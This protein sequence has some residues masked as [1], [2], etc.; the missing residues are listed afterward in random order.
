MR[1]IPTVFGVAAPVVLALASISVGTASAASPP[2]PLTTLQWQAEI[3]Q[4]PAV[5][6]GCFH[7]SF[8][9][10][11]WQAVACVKAPELPFS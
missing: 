7:A 2:T 9:A 6:S 11:V 10:L 8:P 4:V 3:G 1:K 5:G